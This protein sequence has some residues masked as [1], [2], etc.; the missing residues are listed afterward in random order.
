MSDGSTD[1]AGSHGGSIRA[2][3]WALGANGGIAAAKL[4]AAAYTGSGSMLAE[5]IHSLA[6]CANQLLLLIGMR[7]ARADISEIHPLGS[8]RVVYFYAMMVALMLFTLG[9]A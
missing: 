6:D 1:S 2:I 5:A 4:A 9:G 8:G 3:L 7:Q